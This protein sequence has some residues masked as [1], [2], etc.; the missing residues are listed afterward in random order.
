MQR[1]YS[2]AIFEPV[3]NWEGSAFD[4]AF[5]GNVMAEDNWDFIWGAATYN[6]GWDLKKDILSL[7]SVTLQK[8]W[9]EIR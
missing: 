5:K 7:K 3:N 6:G 1:R 2:L 8:E 9:K 4:L